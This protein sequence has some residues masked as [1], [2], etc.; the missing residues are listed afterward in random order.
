MRWHGAVAVLLA[1]TALAPAVQADATWQ[2]PRQVGRASTAGALALTNAGTLLGASS[3]VGRAQIDLFTLPPGATRI[4]RERVHLPKS[5]PRS[6]FFPLTGGL[7]IVANIRGDRLLATDY[8]IGTQVKVAVRSAPAGAGLGPWVRLP[9]RNAD[10]GLAQLSPD[11]RAL[12][13][14]RDR[15]TRTVGY[16]SARVGARDWRSGRIPIAV[17]KVAAT[18]TR[19]GSVLWTWVASTVTD[20][21][22]NSFHEE[23]FVRLT[24]LLTRRFASGRRVLANDLEPQTSESIQGAALVTAVN[25]HQVAVWAGGNGVR[26]ARR[27]SGAYGP[28]REVALPE[29]RASNVFVA[30]NAT[31]DAIFLCVISSSEVYALVSRGARMP[32]GPFRVTPPEPEHKPFGTI[33]LAAIDRAGRAVITWTGHELG[34]TGTGSVWATAIGRSGRPSAPRLIAGGANTASHVAI[35]NR[36]EAAIVWTRSNHLM[37]SRGRID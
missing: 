11:G 30:S 16:A 20:A 17:T 27:A 14:W 29:G 15:E 19:G 23:M 25:G 33:P 18:F 32:R 24:S 28:V 7:R 2:H 9:A 10:L 4:R 13:V 8:A 5:R 37:V 3:P 6:G 21:L 22:S 35:N 12:V 1:T 31:G 36:G 34:N 26:V